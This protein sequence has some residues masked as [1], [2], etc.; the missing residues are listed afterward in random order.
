M[1]TIFIILLAL[2]LQMCATRPQTKQR[3]CFKGKLVKRGI[4]G[5]RVIQLLSEP[6]AGIAFAVNWTDSLSGK[7]YAKVFSVGN[8]CDFPVSVKEGD[9]FSFTLTNIPAP[10]CIQCYA[11]T[12]VP[13]EKNNVAVGCGK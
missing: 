6:S 8:T 7:Q 10:D 2:S 12:P 5:Q 1:K 11:Y 9:E 4:C 13:A 3:G